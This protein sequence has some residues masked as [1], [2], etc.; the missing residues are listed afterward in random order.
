MSR[1]ILNAI[2]VCLDSYS[3]L[4]SL[5]IVVS[6]FSIKKVE[7][8]AKWFAYT[9]ISAIIYG[10][11]DLVMWI[12]EG[13]DAAWKLIVLPVYSFIFY[14]SGILI[15]LFYI[16]YIIEYYSVYEKLSR[17]WWYFCIGMIVIYNVFTCLTTIHH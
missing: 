10:A 16:R 14:F 11:A 12:S 6:I 8:S 13:T 4:I 3:I 9:N 15:F 17:K 2:N 7:S 1:E 5:I